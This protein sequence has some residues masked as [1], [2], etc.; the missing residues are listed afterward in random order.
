[1]AKYYSKRASKK[2][3]YKK[4]RTIRKLKTTLRRKLQRGGMMSIFTMKLIMIVLG[5]VISS[6][7]TLLSIC[8]F[9]LIR[10]KSKDTYSTYYPPN[11]TQSD[12]TYIKNPDYTPDN[13]PDNTP[14]NQKQIGG[15]NPSLFNALNEI[16]QRF[17]DGNGPTNSS[18]KQQ[19]IDCMEQLRKNINEGKFDNPITNAPPVQPLTPESITELLEK[20]PAATEPEVSLE[21]TPV[22]ERVKKIVISKIEYLKGHLKK[23]LDVPIDAFKRRYGLADDDMKC[24][25][26]VIGIIVD[27]ILSKKDVLFEKMKEH[28]RFKS[29]LENSNKASELAAA[30]RERVSNF[31]GSLGDKTGSFMNSMRG[32]TGPVHDSVPLSES[33]PVEQKPVLDRIG[34]FFGRK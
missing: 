8:K 15:S 16:N 18:V 6:N 25:K 29:I 24:L 27:D 31:A 30:G 14:E 28:P 2:R 33:L 11:Y 20:A 34:S 9:F 13:T 10:E 23:M 5:L 17:N 19:Y 26:Q 1:M 12:E 32:N 22:V 3:A 21:N 4:R 7:P